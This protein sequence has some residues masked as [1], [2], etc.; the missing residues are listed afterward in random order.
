M[1]REELTSFV[2]TSEE[3]KKKKRGEKKQ[4]YNTFLT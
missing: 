4:T 1:I 2:P 3:K